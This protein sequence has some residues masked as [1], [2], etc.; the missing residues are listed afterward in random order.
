MNQKNQAPFT[1]PVDF[2]PKKGVLE[3]KSQSPFDPDYKSKIDADKP[4]FRNHDVK[5]VSTGTIY[6]R[7]SET[8]DKPD[9]P[10]GADTI[11]GEKRGRGRPPGKYGSY[12]KRIKEALEN[13]SMVSEEQLD[14]LSKTTLGNYAS[15]A[16]NDV[17]NSNQANIRWKEHEKKQ[18]LSPEEKTWKNNN[19]RKAK[20]REKGV[21]S[22][23]SRLT[24]ESLEIGNKVSVD[25]KVGIVEHIVGSDILV[26]LEEG[27]QRFHIDNI[28][29]LEET[30]KDNTLLEGVSWDRWNS[31]HELQ[32]KENIGTWMVSL[33]ENGYSYGDVE[34][35]DFMTVKGNGLDAAEFASKLAKD[36]NSTVYI[37]ESFTPEKEDKYALSLTKLFHSAFSLK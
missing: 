8:F 13:H 26:K 21:R 22:V 7:K 16:M 3:E 2:A 18:A 23:L 17:R 20:T 24:K 36:N 11:P 5:K 25:G 32:E 6:T 34:G 31:V 4:K 37:L 15:G 10:A 28:N 29:L 14:E 33:N 30:S 1:F 35:T 12:K 27:I 9:A 19:I